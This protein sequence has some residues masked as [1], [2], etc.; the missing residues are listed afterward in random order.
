VT[1]EVRWSPRA[2]K[3]MRRLD[4]KVARRV[5]RAVD[6]LVGEGYGDVTK[7][8]DVDPAEWRLRVGSARIRFRYRKKQ[9]IVEV[10]RVLPRGK[11]Y[12]R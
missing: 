3:D 5:G 11:A 7:L 8:T 2:L 9:R 6:R 4:D 12:D 1:W 10:L